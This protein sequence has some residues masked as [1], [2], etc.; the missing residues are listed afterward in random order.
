[1]ELKEEDYSSEGLKI[2][3]SPGCMLNPRV[4]L[5]G[6]ISAIEVE[7]S[8]VVTLTIPI[9]VEPRLTIISALV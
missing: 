5:D 6:I 4:I 3:S 7:G 8:R 9:F 2:T 1:M